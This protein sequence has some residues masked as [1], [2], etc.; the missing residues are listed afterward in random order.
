MTLSL[1]RLSVLLL[2]AGAIQAEPTDLSASSTSVVE[3]STVSLPPQ[4]DLAEATF[5]PEPLDFT[6][7]ASRTQRVQVT[8]AP[9]MEGLPPVTGTATLKVEMVE[10]PE[11]PA[12]VE[13][14]GE[15]PAQDAAATAQIQ[16]FREQHP[17]G[18]FIFISATVYDHVR[19]YLRIFPNG[20]ADRE[21]AVWSNVDFN[22]FAGLGSFRVK[23]ADGTSRDIGLMMSLGNES[24]IKDGAPSL[25][26][27]A[28][29]GPSFI[30]TKGD[31]PEAVESLKRL[32]QLYRNE[33][34]TLK[35]ASL[36]RTKALEAKKA[37]FLASPPKPADVTVRF[38]Q[39]PESTASASEQP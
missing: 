38:W 1:S 27:L 19:T 11:L 31:C 39:R 22:H 13:P 23:D 18:E 28:A 4:V 32:H 25:P 37:A 12:P 9:P 8:Q 5:K 15:L 14:L 33:G 35:Q 34:E 2:T 3:D 26:A 36:A 17:S 29:A 24:G 10:A 21:V 30:V 6:V 20:Q 7:L 16:E